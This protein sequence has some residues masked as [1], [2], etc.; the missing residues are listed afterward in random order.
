MT[1]WYCFQ[2]QKTVDYGWWF[3]DS[4][5]TVLRSIKGGMNRFISQKCPEIQYF[6]RISLKNDPGDPSVS[7]YKN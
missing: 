1:L 6:R 7:G 2:T 3:T 5:H 4:L